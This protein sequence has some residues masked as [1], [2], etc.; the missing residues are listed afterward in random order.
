M[1]KARAKA[2]MIE[3]NIPKQDH[4]EVEADVPK[5]FLIAI[6]AIGNIANDIIQEPDDSINII[7]KENDNLKFSSIFFDAYLN[8]QFETESD[9]YFY[10]FGSIAYFF[11]DY[12]GNSKV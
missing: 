10:L 12:I 5:L 3:Y 4:I 9:Y 1:K 6:S 8:A 7:K 11:N 2:K